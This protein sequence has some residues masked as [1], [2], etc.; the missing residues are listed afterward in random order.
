MRPLMDDTLHNKHLFFFV[1]YQT[2]KKREK[3]DKARSLYLFYRHDFRD[4][5]QTKPSNRADHLYYIF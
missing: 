3:I 2:G 5:A 1:H 4:T